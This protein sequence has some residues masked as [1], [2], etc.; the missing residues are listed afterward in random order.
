MRSTKL[1][2]SS[3]VSALVIFRRGNEV[4]S[5]V[6]DGFPVYDRV[7]RIPLYIVGPRQNLSLLYRREDLY[8]DF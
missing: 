8:T 1:G 3:E 4:K 2:I 6:N 5:N 7:V